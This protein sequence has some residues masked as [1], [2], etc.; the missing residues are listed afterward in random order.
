MKRFEL[1]GW[2]LIVLM[3]AALGVAVWAVA[4]EELLALWE[5]FF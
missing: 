2:L 1:P 4:N 5:D 3:T